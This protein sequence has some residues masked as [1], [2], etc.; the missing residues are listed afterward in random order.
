MSRALLCGLLALVLL[1]GQMGCARTVVRR[2]PDACDE[3]LRFYR[4]KPYLLLSPKEGDTTK[5]VISLQYM[6][7]FSEEYSVQAYTGFI[8]TNKTEV[9]LNESGVLTALNVSVDSKASEF[10]KSVGELIGSLP[11]PTAKESAVPSPAIRSEGMAV[12]AYRVPLGYYEAVVSRGPD[13]RKH[14]YGW[15]YVGFAPFNQCPLESTGMECTDCCSSSLFGLVSESGTLVFKRIDELAHDTITVTTAAT[16]SSPAND[17][18]L[19]LQLQNAINGFLESSDVRPRGG[20]SVEIDRIA[21][22]V[23]F[24]S[25]HPIQ[26]SAGFNAEA[27]GKTMQQIVNDLLQGYVAVNN[28]YIS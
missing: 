6:P 13:C 7:D 10:V 18:A 25:E 8:G 5:V 2:N 22:T 3:G 17:A 12:R 19:V 15:R 14:L 4:S 27:L 26:A 9:S 1:T 21:R 20:I 28:T 11:E 16:T 24:S 23:T